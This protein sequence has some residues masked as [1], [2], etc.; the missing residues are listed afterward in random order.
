MLEKLDEWTVLG[1]VPNG[2]AFPLTVCRKKKGKM[3]TL[4]AIPTSTTLNFYTP[5][6]PHSLPLTPVTSTHL[7]PVTCTEDQAI[8]HPI[9][10][11][12]TAVE[13]KLK[14]AMKIYFGM[15]NYNFYMLGKFAKALPSKI[16]IY[17]A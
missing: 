4:R 6:L 13:R 16:K 3:Q 1:A 2:P 5:L 17:L 15:P 7:N 9:P 12:T 14:V 11:Y 8:P 10:T